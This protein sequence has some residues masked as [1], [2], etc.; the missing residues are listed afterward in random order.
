[1]LTPDAI[2]AVNE[3]VYKQPRAVKEISELLKVSWV[4]ADKYLNYMIEKY[5][6]IKI[7]TFRGGTRGALKIVYWANLEG[8]RASTA[9]QILL[10]KIKTGKKKQDF[11]PFDIYSLVDHNK[12]DAFVM[13]NDKADEQKLIDLIKNT[14]RQL[15]IFSGNISFINNTENG[16]RLIDIIVELARKRINI[17]ILCRVDIASIANIKK[18]LELNNLIGYDAVEVRH[19]EQP[20]RGF[21]IDDKIIR[22]RDEKKK[23]DYKDNEINKDVYLIYNIYD[24]EWVEWLEKVFWNLHSNALP[25]ENRINDLEKIEDL[26]IGNKI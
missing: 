15:F 13:P 19:I 22:L 2:K 25:I 10:D 26:L 18:I 7:K 24:K 4:T 23:S 8:M 17:K 1:M 14:S 6:T 5:G 11:N 16:K 9:Q 20:L 3:F 21:V 12:K